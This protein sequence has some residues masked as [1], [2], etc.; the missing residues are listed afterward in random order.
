M[1]RLRGLA[2][3]AHVTR[4]RA[5][6]TAES[7]DVAAA[8]SAEYGC[9]FGKRNLRHMWWAIVCNLHCW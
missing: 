1:N 2:S 5:R 8:L 4:S 3:H 7:S 6:H 9:G